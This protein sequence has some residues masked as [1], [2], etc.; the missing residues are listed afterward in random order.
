MRKSWIDTLAGI[1]DSVPAPRW[2]VYTAVSLVIA[3]VEHVAFWADDRVPFPDIEPSL[4]IGSALPA[5]ILWSMQVLNGVALRALRNLRPA[6][7]LSTADQDALAADLLR[8]PATTSMLLVPVGVLV[9]TASVLTSP[10][11]WGLGET[12]ALSW[13]ASI[14]IA[15]GTVVLTFGFLDHVVHQLRVVDRVHRRSVRVDLFNLEPLYAFSSLTSRTGIVLLAIEVLAIGGLT[16][17]SAGLVGL[18]AGGMVGLS[19]GDIVVTL[20]MFGVAIACF[21]VPLLGLHERIGEEKDRRLTEANGTLAQVLAEVQRRVA[22]GD[23]DGAGR[24]NDTVAA[25]S[26]GLLAVSRVST[27]PWRPETLRGFVSAVL[28]PIVLWLIFELLRRILSA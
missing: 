2:A 26:A 12:G 18:S 24:L 7:E 3:L 4:V 9:G 6:L 17:T 13:A 14:A 21:V 5:V 22:Q 8:T 1:V 28:L 25:A 27:W 11:A 20:V 16:L 10:E 15:I 19:S 23:M